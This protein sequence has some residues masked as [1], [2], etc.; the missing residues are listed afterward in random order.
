[1]NLIEIALQIIGL[2]IIAVALSYFRG[3]KKIITTGCVQEVTE[4][5]LGLMFV[6]NGQKCGIFLSNRYKLAEGDEVS[7]FGTRNINGISVLSLINKTNNYAIKPKFLL[8]CL[9]FI[10]T[11]VMSTI[12]S[13]VNSIYNQLVISPALQQVFSIIFLLLSGYYLSLIYWKYKSI[14]MLKKSISTK[15]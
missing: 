2:F 13:N 10:F 6:L 14:S 15:L 9:L 3:R 1:M 5:P 4:T 11:F 7:L 12:M 8:D